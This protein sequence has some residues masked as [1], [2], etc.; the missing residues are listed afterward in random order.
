MKERFINIQEWMI[1]LELKGNELILF[2]LIY[3]F[4][5]DG[6]SEFAGSLDYMCK[7]T[8]STKPGVLKSLKSLLDKGL[9]TKRKVLNKVYYA[10]KFNEEVNKVESDGKQS[11]MDGKQ[12]LP[13][14]T[15]N[16]I[17]LKHSN[18]INKKSKKEFIP[19][20]LDEIKNYIQEKNIRWM[21][22]LSW[23]ITKQQ[24]GMILMAKN[25]KLERESCYL[26]F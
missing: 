25:K 3:G 10:T 15:I 13:N 18:N 20:T 9:I 21:L 11:L 7:W 8:N 14:N 1:N 24:N 16:N 22:K 5:Q 19:P 12:S 17:N 23:I 4:S 2:A 6:E 26:E